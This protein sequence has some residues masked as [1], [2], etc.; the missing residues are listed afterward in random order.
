MPQP[1]LE[2]LWEGAEATVALKTR[3]RFT[4]ASHAAAWL[5]GTLQERWGLRVETC[6]RLVISANKLLAWLTVDGQRLIA[7]CSSEPGLF[8][9]LA[10][11][12]AVTSWLDG[13]GIPVA[14]P[15]A[16]VDGNMRVNRDGYSLGL[17]P[18]VGGDLLDV[19]D[20]AEVVAAGRML[21][22]VHR[23][24]AAYPQPFA[25]ASPSKG[26]QLVH[27][28][29][30]SANILHDGN[31]I[32][33]ILDFDEASYRTRIAEVAQSAVLLGTRYHNWQP[34]T[35]ATRTTFVSAYNNVSP[36]TR[37]ERDQFDHVVAS[38]SADFD[39][40]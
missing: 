18:H 25:G 14:V 17:Y 1:R 38:V 6:D 10:D 16:T 5:S 40:S 33:A 29:F 23:A 28:D 21:A 35:P 2:M 11:I 36:L 15:I 31:E 7:K 39:W 24:L 8:A 30:R 22:M 20:D 32:S 3:F 27:G 4:D 19:E 26:Q 13:Q 9:R 37:A 34:T 12:D